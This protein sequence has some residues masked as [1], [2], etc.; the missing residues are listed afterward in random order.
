[1]SEIR[2]YHENHPDEVLQHSRTHAE[3]AKILRAAGVRFEQW[4]TEG[5]VKAG[6]SEMDV[7]GAY[8]TDIDRLM[9]EGGYHKVDVI[10]LNTNHPDKQILRKKFLSEHTHAEDEVRFF[11][12]GQGLFS[13]H[14][15]NRV[16]EVLCVKGDLIS[17]PAQIPH[18]FDMGSNPHL[19]AIRLFTNPEGWVAHYTG[20]P[21]ADNFSRLEN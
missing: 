17:V 4:H 20:A 3:I 9:L 21:I 13:L 2:V 19:V 11:V 15:G 14:I 6:D 8:I 5:S 10:S 16:Y 7:L 18:W 12:E 1:M